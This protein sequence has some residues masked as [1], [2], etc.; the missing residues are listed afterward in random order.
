MASAVEK[1]RQGRRKAQPLRPERNGLGCALSTLALVFAA[2]LTFLA[3]LLPPFSLAEQLF[4]TP[5][6]PLNNRL[7]SDD[8]IL[9]AAGANSLNIRLSKLSAAAFSGLPEPQ[10]DLLRQARAAL[11]RTLAPLSSIYRLEQR[12]TPPDSLTLAFALPD[13]VEPAQADLY[14]YDAALG[15]WRF[16]PAQRAVIDGR[17]SLVAVLNNVQRLPEA[18][19]IGRLAL[20]V[21]VVSVVIE[22]G[23]AFKPEVAAV[24]NVVHPAGLMPNVEGAL[25]GALPSGVA[26][27]DS[28]AVVPI[29]RNY[30]GNSAPDAALIEAL[31][32]EPERR[33]AHLDYLLEFARSQ[34]Y[35][36]IAI[37]YLDLPS[38]LRDAYSAFISALASALHAE[39]RS[40]TLVLP[41]PTPSGSQFETGA[42]D[43]RTLGALADSVQIILPLNPRDYLPEGVVRRAMAWAVG[44]ISRAKLH[45]VISVRSVVQEGSQWLPIS[46]REALAPLSELRV[47]PEG[48]LAPDTPVQL[49]IAPERA[50]FGVEASMPVVRYKSVEGSFTRAVWLMTS[51]ALRDRLGTLLVNNWAGVQVPDFAA[52][53]AYL[54]GTRVLA[55]YKT[56]RA[57]QTWFVPVPADLAVQ[58]RVSV[59]ETVLAEQTE[60]IGQPFVFTPDGTYRDIQVSAVL[61]ELDFPLARV[62]LQVARSQS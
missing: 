61:A 4:G 44:E 25:D 57:G 32:N 27:G 53:G 46:Y 18:L 62:T 40:L 29:I 50:A 43:W 10:D 41:F 34:P 6:L 51:S 14:G 22:A 2:M 52:D 3:L 42:Y 54:Q 16:I 21:P 24:A 59:G 26:F 8:L 58:W 5:F 37:E 20:Q 12:G 33:Q 47:T 17:L 56:Y 1:G 60:G 48:V 38:S 23:Q 49:Q 19:F 9:T 28:Y 11:P 36:G 55:Q 45:A 15:H 30:R 7:V 31:L 13:G 39:G 35:S